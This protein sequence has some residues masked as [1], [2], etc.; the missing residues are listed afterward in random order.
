MQ[1]VSDNILL[2]T[3]KSSDGHSQT[4]QGSNEATISYPQSSLFCKLISNQ[5][6]WDKLAKAA[7]YS[8][9]LEIQTDQNAPR[10]TAK[11]LLETD[12]R[13]FLEE[14]YQ[15]KTAMLKMEPLEATP[16]NDISKRIMRICLIFLAGGNA[17]RQVFFTAL[18]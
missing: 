2:L 12:R 1:Q 5:D 9:E 11:A 13:L 10:R 6:D 14:R 7:D 18:L 4:M 17:H 16:K 8:N 15:Y 3:Y